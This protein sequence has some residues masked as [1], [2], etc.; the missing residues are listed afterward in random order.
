MAGREICESLR[1]SYDHKKIDV[2]LFGGRDDNSLISDFKKRALQ[3]PTILSDLTLRD[4]MAALSYCT[5]LLCNNSGPLHI[6][7]ALQIPTVSTMGPTEPSRW[8]PQGDTHLVLR[9]DLDCSP[10]RRGYCENHDC[11]KLITTDDFLSAVQKQLR[12]LSH[13]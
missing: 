7:T 6:A 8:W 3:T 12:Y 13:S 1:I 2:I 5:L 9:K 4:F 11:M 10:C